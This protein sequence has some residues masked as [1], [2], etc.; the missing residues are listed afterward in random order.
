MKNYISVT[1][2]NF[3]NVNNDVNGNP[4]QVI[5]F[6]NISIPTND[7]GGVLK[8][9]R[10]ALNICKDIFGY[11]K[12]YDTKKI[13]GS[14]LVSSYNLNDEVAMIN[15]HNIKVFIDQ[16]LMNDHV[17]SYKFLNP[18]YKMIQYTITDSQNNFDDR[19]C[20]VF[21]DSKAD[22]KAIRFALANKSLISFN[23]VK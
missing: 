22:E 7:Q 15:A 3:T 11:C 19:D 20:H 13:T 23:E 14:I 6:T 21:I 10:T 16:I 5:H 9:Y 4:R 12:K 1:K 2:D 17:V 18:D 8:D